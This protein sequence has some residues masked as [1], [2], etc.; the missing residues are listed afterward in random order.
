MSKQ[1]VEI[2]EQNAIYDK[3]KEF[4]SGSLLIN[5]LNHNAYGGTKQDLAEGIAS[6]ELSSEAKLY[7]TRI[8][9]EVEEI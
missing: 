1:I 2:V 6:G 9:I 4:M 7:K 3:R 5:I 8:I